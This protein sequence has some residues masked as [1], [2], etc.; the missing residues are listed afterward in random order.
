MEGTNPQVISLRTGAARRGGRC[1]RAEAEQCRRGFSPECGRE[2][3][4]CRFPTVDRGVLRRRPYS[5]LA[6]EDSRQVQT[7][8]GEGGWASIAIR[9]ID[10]ACVLPERDLVR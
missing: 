4:S 6:F 5:R 10:V 2:A 7:I 8:L 9:P 1:L 3:V